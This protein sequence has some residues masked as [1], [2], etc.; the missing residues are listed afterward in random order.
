MSD[1]DEPVEDQPTKRSKKPML[2]GLV[3]AIVLGGG[4]FY[5]VFSG[6]ILA[7]TGH[8]EGDMENQIIAGP[9]PDVVFVPLQPLVVNIGSGTKSQHLLF[10]AELEVKRSAEEDVLT[11]L[12][13]VTD[14]LN[15]YLRAVDI[16]KLEQRTALI[17]LRSQMLRRVQVVTGEGR[18]NDLLVMEFVIN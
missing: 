12:P 11:L 14:V 9:L 10:R 13:R 1:T 17:Q 3:L 15:S 7:P 8:A 16:S 4:G 5:T 2:I 18:V 6:L